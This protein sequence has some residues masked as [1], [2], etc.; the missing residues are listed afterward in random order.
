[1][2]KPFFGLCKN[3]EITTVQFHRE[4]N[5]NETLVDSAWK[6]VPR[7]ILVFLQFLMEMNKYSVPSFV[8]QFSNLLQEDIHRCFSKSVGIEREEYFSTYKRRARGF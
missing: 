8:E 7:P 4:E 3:S 5:T 6:V 1:M 2:R